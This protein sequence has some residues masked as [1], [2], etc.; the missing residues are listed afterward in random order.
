MVLLD[1]Y[2]L[3]RLK[4]EVLRQEVQTLQET[5]QICPKLVVVLL[6]TDNA[7]VLYV[8]MKARAC[9]RVGMDCVLK[10]LSGQTSQAELL[11]LLDGYNRDVSVHGILVQ[12]PLPKHIDTRRVIEAIAPHKDVDGFHPLNVGRVYSN[13]L[14]TGFLPATAMGVMQLLEHYEIDVRGKNVAIVGASNIIGKPLASLMLNAGAT[15]S[16][17]HILTKDISLYTKKADIV[18]VGVGQP[19]LL[20]ADMV[21]EGAVVVDIGISKVGGKVVG[22]A[23]FEGLEGKVSFITPVPKGVGP[24]TIVCLL[25]NTLYAAK[26]CA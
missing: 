18:C 8:N 21:K 24:M 13:S 14:Y 2:A 20:K 26:G 7:S 23:D 15:I 22:D 17:C 3:A 25:Q 10:S 5:R 9:A 6:G 4:E 1:G 19:K 11:E 12:L 16:L